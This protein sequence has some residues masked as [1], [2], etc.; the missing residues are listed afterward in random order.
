M[1]DRID[2]GFIEGIE[3]MQLEAYVIPGRPN[4]GVTIAMGFDLGHWTE[5]DLRRAR[6]RPETVELLRPFLGKKGAEAGQLLAAYVTANGDKK[7]TIDRQDA[8]RLNDL[9]RDEIVGPLK[10]NYDTDIRTGP[11][12][13]EDLPEPAQTVLASVAWQYGPNL[14]ARTPRLWD[15]MTRRNWAAA[16]REL[17][18]FGDD[19]GRRRRIE[20]DRL[21]T[22]VD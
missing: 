4:A 5:S 11:T 18:N 2:W 10:R 17:R 19:D 1:A 8:D 12:R 22:I 6:L 13:F 15:H 20:A 7:L 9:G 3:K 21:E 14:A 16:V